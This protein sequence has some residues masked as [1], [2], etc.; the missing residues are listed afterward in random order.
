MDQPLIL[1]DLRNI[2]YNNVGV[3]AVRCIT[4]TNQTGTISGRNYSTVR[5]D[6]NTNLINNSILIPP[7]GGMFEVKYKNFDLIGRSS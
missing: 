3:L 5:Y 6:V 7:P 4:A 2:I 1:D